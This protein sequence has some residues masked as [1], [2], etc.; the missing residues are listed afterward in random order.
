[1]PCD[2]DEEPSMTQM[3]R[4]API[5]LGLGIAL[6]LVWAV[7]RAEARTENLEW[8][9]P[10]G[11]AIGGF[12]V[13]YGTS[14]RNYTT[15]LDVGPIAKSGD[16]YA[17]ALTVPDDATVYIAVRAYDPDGNRSLASNERVRYSPTAPPPTEPDPVVTEPTTP[18]SPAPAGDA[19]PPAAFSPAGDLTFDFDT[20]S[21]G[22]SVSGWVDTG[23]DNSLSIDD[24][25]FRVVDVNGNHVLA[26]T[27]TETNIHSH[28]VDGESRSW[29]GYEFRGAMLI[30]DASGG[31]GVTAHSLYPDQ[32]NY[33]RLR[34]Y[35]SNAFELAPHTG[36]FTCANT[37]TGVVPQPGVWYRF[38]LRIDVTSSS[39][40]V[41]A[42]VW[43]DGSA[44]PSSPQADCTDT[45]SSRPSVGTVGVWAMG[46]GAKYWD[47]LDVEGIAGDATSAPATP[48]EPPVLIEVVP[49]P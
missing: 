32:D 18:T 24:S 48:P 26:T 34:R 42:K 10:S 40:R 45:S 39:N 31:I 12:E 38:S 47:V 37:N 29:S 15:E 44:E 46:P 8:E 11:V 20:A 17:Y 43:P 49:A 4:R 28:Y 41:T 3:P 14:S 5:A 22:S 13:L 7:D 9:Y 36:S 35:Q 2:P 23:P 27:S 25:L 19:E 6:S 1:M 21:V 30:T 16:H 33:Y